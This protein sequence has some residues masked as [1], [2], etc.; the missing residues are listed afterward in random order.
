MSFSKRQKISKKR[1]ED[2]FSATKTLQKSDNRQVGK[3]GKILTVD[4][5][6][7]PTFGKIEKTRGGIQK[8]NQ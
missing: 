7:R 1:K 6:G 8:H 3:V 2:I 5:T 4:F